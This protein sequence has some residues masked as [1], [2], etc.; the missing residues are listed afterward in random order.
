MSHL[1]RDRKTWVPLPSLA[2]L[3]PDGGAANFGLNFLTFIILFNNLIPIS[4]LVTLEVIKFIQAFFINW[5]S[6][7]LSHRSC[8]CLMNLLSLKC[9]L[10]KPPGP[11]LEN[12]TA[13]MKVELYQN[14]PYE[15]AKIGFRAG[16]L[17]HRC[18]GVLSSHWMARL[19]SGGCFDWQ[20]MKIKE[21]LVMFWSPDGKVLIKN[22]C[23]Y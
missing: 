9:R 4:L 20:S 3:F 7:S 15:D 11:I 14:N 18:N 13:Q 17:K 5:V 8:S 6:A 19:L 23:E 21:V 12:F 22:G 16:R 10:L 1:Y 2:F